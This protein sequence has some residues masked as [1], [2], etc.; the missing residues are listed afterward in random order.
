MRFQQETLWKKEDLID[1]RPWANDI[2][3]K[4]ILEHLGREGKRERDR[5]PGISQYLISKKWIGG[6]EKKGKR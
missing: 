2:A 4:F 1:L 6:K 3:V 5:V